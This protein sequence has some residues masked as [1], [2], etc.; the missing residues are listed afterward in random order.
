VALFIA[1]IAWVGGRRLRLRLIQWTGRAVTTRIFR[2]QWH[3][4]LPILYTFHW[5]TTELARRYGDA[6]GRSRT[7][8]T[9]SDRADRLRR[10]G[11]PSEA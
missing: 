7:G 11:E 8:A 1:R 9:G 4:M 10:P 5:G 6:I 2:W 3:E